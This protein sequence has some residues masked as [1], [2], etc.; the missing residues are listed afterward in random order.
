MAKK[1]KTHIRESWK[2]TSRKGNNLGRNSSRRHY[3]LAWNSGVWAVFIGW[4]LLVSADVSQS[5]QK[6]IGISYIMSTNIKNHIFGIGWIM[7]AD[8]N[9]TGYK[10]SNPTDAK[11]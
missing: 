9:N 11:P 6:I 4:A 3:V 5:I 2:N 8:T 10:G 7:S 1:G